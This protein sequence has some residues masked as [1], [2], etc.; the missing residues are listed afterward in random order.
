MGAAFTVGIVMLHTEQQKWPASQGAYGYSGMPGGPNRLVHELAREIEETQRRQGETIASIVERLRALDLRR[1]DQTHPAGEE[2]WDAASAEALMRTYETDAASQHAAATEA[3]DRQDWL[4][5]RFYDIADRIK[6]TL[7]DLK[8]GSTMMLLEERLD[9]FQKH[10]S[11][12]LEDVVRRSDLDGLRLIETHISFLGDKLDELDRHVAR[13]DG[14]EADVRSVMEQVSDERIA[15]LL[16]YDTRFAADIEAVAVRAAEEVHAR[17]GQDG[18]RASAE[19]ARHQELRD[20]IEASIQDRRQAEAAAT[21][22]V[23]GLSGRVNAQADRYDELKVLLEQAIQ[24]QRQN[25][26]TAFGML[27]TLQQAMVRILD[28]MDSLEQQGQPATTVPWPVAEPAAETQMFASFNDEPARRYAAAPA[29][30]DIAPADFSASRFQ[31]RFHDQGEAADPMLVAPVEVPSVFAAPA[32]ADVSASTDEAASPVDRLRRDFI[33]DARRAK[34]KAAANRAEAIAEKTEVSRRPAAEPA[35]AALAQAARLPFAAGAGRLFGASPKLLAAALAFV[36]AINGGIL[37]LNRKSSPP[38]APQ[39]TIQ[40]EGI[41]A[42]PEAPA[43]SGSEAAP[44][45][46]PEPAPNTAPRSD[47]TDDET[48]FAQF[49]PPAATAEPQQADPTGSSALT[50]YGFMDDVLDPPALETSG[51]PASP[52]RG[53]TIAGANGAV[54]DAMV[55]DVYQQQV[56]ASLSGKLGTIA[57]AQSPD[58][59]LPEQS[60]RV[61]TAYTEPASTPDT[62]DGAQRSSALDLPPATV[63]PLS[64]RLAAA[65]GDASAEFE[66]AARLAEGKG[67]S[68]DFAEALRWYQRSATKG[69]AQ[70]QYRL[71]TL[72]ERGLGV[73]KDIGRARIW[74]SRAAEQGNVKSM[75]N[76]A[77]LAAGG[78]QGEPDYTTATQWF[79]KAASHGLSDSQYNLGVLL[80]NGLGVKADRVE[81]YKWYALAAKN[82]D[83]DAKARRD[84]LKGTLSA[85][86]LAIAESLVS[87]FKAQ[88]PVPL[89]NDAR[90]AGEDWKKRVNNDA[91]G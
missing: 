68:Q 12:A 35:R 70:A 89:A 30:A 32:D 75:H 39:I 42:E 46:T 37:L 49:V 25:E 86:D 16:D 8:P 33:A 11:S 17:L 76:L 5:H 21:S 31:D 79:T 2:P 82:G 55:A 65:N 59:L 69:F 78:E 24:E 22:L 28:R 64:L 1:P 67:T 3:Q 72:Y 84:E 10:I 74:Y 18:E 87:S 73:T 23:T 29:P 83:T 57:A 27:D 56:L 20:L 58:A 50:P 71:G 34:L 4:G 26:Q 53:M 6:R 85:S 19:A 41:G 80:E 91:N 62:V 77:V 15:K 88:T 52:P 44:Q 61:E 63:G 66:V 48:G 43:A 51:A 81:A 38:P 9:Q 13:I 47:L 14:I 90:A 45:Q 36:V 54:P 40:P 7:A 60:G